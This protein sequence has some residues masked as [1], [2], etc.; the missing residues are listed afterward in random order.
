MWC[1]EFLV[2][3]IDVCYL[4]GC[5]TWLWVGSW[6]LIG[7]FCL[8]VFGVACVAV[9]ACLLVMIVWLPVFVYCLLVAVWVWIGLDY[10]VGFMLICCGIRLVVV[11]CGGLIVL[12]DVLGVTC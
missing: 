1:F 6:L 2:T 5:I 4:G 9:F 11:R 8:V 3:A 7:C 12:C 10:V